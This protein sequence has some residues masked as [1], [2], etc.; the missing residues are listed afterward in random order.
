MDHGD[1]AGGVD[2]GYNGGHLV[3]GDVE[4][5]A[6]YPP[7]LFEVIRGGVEILM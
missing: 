6:A 7:D 1:S 3:G 2:L 4:V 5:S